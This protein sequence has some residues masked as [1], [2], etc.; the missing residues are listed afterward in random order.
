MADQAERLKT[1]ADNLEKTYQALR[2]AASNIAG[3]V[4]AGQATCD[5][6]KAY[7]LWALAIYNTQKGMLAALR[8]GGEQGVPDL[9]A[10][11]TLFVW[12]G[13]SGAD[14]WRIDC[15]G[16][17]SSLQGLMS[18]A[19]KGPTP[20]SQYLSTNEIEIQ[21][22]DPYLYN[23]SA[24]PSFSA[25]AQVTQ[26]RQGLGIAPLIALII[27]A[28][29]AITVAVAIT[30]IMHYLEVNEVQEANTKQVQA[31]A[32]A[33]AN[34]TQAR[35]TCLAGCTKEGK[36]TQDCVSICAKL[37]EKP[38]ITLPGQGQPW[39]VLQWIGFTVVMGVG[40]MIAWRMWQ[41]KQA[42]KP[43]FQLPESVEAA[44]HPGH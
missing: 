15:A 36:S 17:P 23:P 19:M 14:A 30:A 22:T 21:T 43:M 18:H 13:I 9:P 5:E 29:I 24:A 40:T 6:V 12:R 10:S 1:I 35:L 20:K 3:L 25:L 26:A 39:G 11:P 41:R 16:Q 2:R 31:Q 34:Y 44:I 28:G 4:Q 27:I 32:D 42:G 37:V 8:A 38:K 7:N 33:F